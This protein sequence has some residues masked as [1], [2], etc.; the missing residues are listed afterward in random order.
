MS[1]ATNAKH[2]RDQNLAVSARLHVLESM[3]ASL[4]SSMAKALGCFTIGDLAIDPDSAFVVFRGSASCLD[5]P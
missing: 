3:T 5:A 4:S 1:R 2:G